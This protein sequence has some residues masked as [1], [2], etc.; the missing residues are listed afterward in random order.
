MLWALLLHYGCTVV[1]FFL[2]KAK[3]T[4]KTRNR[5]LK[6][7]CSRKRKPVGHTVIAWPLSSFQLWFSH[8]WWDC[9]HPTLRTRSLHHP[10]AHAVVAMG[11]LLRHRYNHHEARGEWYP[12][13]W[14]Q[15]LCTAQPYCLSST[16][17]SLRG[18]LLWKG[19]H[20]P[21]NSGAELP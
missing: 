2:K 20:C 10:G 21:R 19:C 16:P 15:Q 8:Q 12:Q 9:H 1:F 17:D 4:K 6:S 11:T 7:S 5:P 3:T 13:L 14:P 18:F